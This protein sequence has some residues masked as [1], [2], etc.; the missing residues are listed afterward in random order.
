L[1]VLSESKFEATFSAKDKAAKLEIIGSDGSD[2]LK[3][4]ATV[5]IQAKEKVNGKYQYLSVGAGLGFLGEFFEYQSGQNTAT[6]EP[7]LAGKIASVMKGF[8]NQPLEFEGTSTNNFE[9]TSTNNFPVIPGALFNNAFAMRLTAIV[10][11]LSISSIRFTASDFGTLYLDGALIA[12][13]TGSAVV[14]DNLALGTGPY[15]LRAVMSKKSKSSQ[16]S[17]KVEYKSTVDGSFSSLPSSSIS[18]PYILSSS[19]PNSKFVVGCIGDSCKS[20]QTCQQID[21]VTNADGTCINPVQT[22]AKQGIQTCSAGR[23][24]AFVLQ[25]QGSDKIGLSNQGLGYE[26]I[27]GTVAVSFVSSDTSS[28]DAQGRAV[29]IT[30]NFARVAS[31][32]TSSDSTNTLLQSAFDFS[33]DHAVRITYGGPA[34][35]VLSVFMG[36]SS[37]SSTTSWKLLLQS[38][39]HMGILPRST[40]FMGFTAST[41]SSFLMRHEVMKWNIINVKTSA[42]NSS[43][44]ASRGSTA[45][46]AA[47]SPVFMLVNPKDSCGIPRETNSLLMRNAASQY[48]SSVKLNNDPIGT[49]AVTPETNIALGQPVYSNVQP[50]T[51]RSICSAS[52]CRTISLAHG[53]SLDLVVDGAVSATFLSKS[54]IDPYVEVDL[55]R[56]S[57]VSVV[58]IVGDTACACFLS[59]YFC[60]PERGSIWFLTKKW[61]LLRRCLRFPQLYRHYMLL[62]ATQV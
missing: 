17:F 20:C 57:S 10:K 25:T 44:S 3:F 2:T 40:A 16:P 35:K 19:Q 14:K 5:S 43:L 31:K 39:V 53:N 55:G 23:G 30:E 7:Y 28:Q 51:G 27:P 46:F 41:Q 34:D 56:N 59:N 8:R 22:C 48:N 50:E 9:G 12:T 1:T 47:G 62:Q 38:K 6:G 24:F 15:I 33:R 18:Y 42:S 13:S 37:I 32:T 49:S 45:Q 58:S 36:G 54:G 61:K 26:G 29:S 21:Y 60:T 11:G 52:V 4:G